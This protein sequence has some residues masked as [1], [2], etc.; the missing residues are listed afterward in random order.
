MYG[1]PIRNMKIS[2]SFKVSE[3]MCP[4]FRGATVKKAGE[5]A[6]SAPRRRPTRFRI[7]SRDDTSFLDRHNAILREK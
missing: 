6:V 5:I 4:E 1:T 7:L 3:H 2:L